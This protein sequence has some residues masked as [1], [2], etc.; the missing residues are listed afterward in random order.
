M[1]IYSFR[2]YRPLLKAW[3]KAQ[4]NGGRGQA[5]RLAK[6]L[7][8]S[9]VLVS[10]IFGGTRT[11]QMDQAFGVANFLGL[12][13][14]E[15]EYFLL[16]V[17]YENAATEPYRQYLKTQ[18]DS[19]QI[20]S[21][22]I[23][24]RV[25]KDIHL[26]EEARAKFYS[27]W[28]YSAVRLL[29]DIPATQTAETIALALG[30]ERKRVHE[31]LEFLVAEGLCSREGGKFKMAVRSTHLEA[32]SPWIY[33]RQL[34]WRQRAQ[35]KMDAAG[36]DALFYTGPMVLSAEDQSWIRER[37]VLLVREVTERARNSPSEKLAC[38]NIDW[39][40]VL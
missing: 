7:R 6:E 32:D 24:N 5:N 28:H 33:S 15:T 4:P 2:S 9:T 21:S 38:L 3:L 34:Q 30:T 39:F 10:Q 40:S 17:S 22:Q 16:L 20:N 14:Q 29:S 19:A 8:V 23:K 1:D 26:S 31:I 13:A 18:I 25:A 27:H 11:L 35:Q 12:S 36:S 37:L